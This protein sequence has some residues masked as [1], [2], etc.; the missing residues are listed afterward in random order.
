MNSDSVSWVTWA[1]FGALAIVGLFLLFLPG[2]IADG[3]KVAASGRIWFLTICG[4]FIFPLWIV[5]LCW[6]LMAETK[7]P[8]VR[9]RVYASRG[10]RG[11]QPQA[12]QDWN[13]VP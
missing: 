3:R 9:R 5:A 10:S 7:Q 4:L 13:I 8:V 2:V 1:A 12:G 6:S 11:S